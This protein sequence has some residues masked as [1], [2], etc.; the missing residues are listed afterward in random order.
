M[1]PASFSRRIGAL[2]IDWFCC[3]LLA[4][5][6]T[7]N[8]WAPLGVF[9]VE[10]LLLLTTL[11]ATFGQRLL[12]LRVVRLGTPGPVPPLPALIRTALLVLVIPAVVWDREGRGLHDKAAKTQVMDTRP[13]SRS[14]AVEGGEP[15][16]QR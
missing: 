7:D 13:T 9:A 2:G 4:R 1:S 10:N 16:R 3:L 15:I 6:L 8:Q 14:S 11:G 12:R 5:A